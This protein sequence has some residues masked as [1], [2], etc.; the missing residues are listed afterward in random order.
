MNVLHL[1]EKH[2]LAPTIPTIING[3]C[4]KKASSYA[5]CVTVLTGFKHFFSC[6]TGSNAAF[7]RFLENPRL[8]VACPPPA[9]CFTDRCSL[10]HIAPSVKPI[11]LR[12]TAELDCPTVTGTS[13]TLFRAQ[14]SPGPRSRA[15]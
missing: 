10:H 8:M 11:L 15:R 9:F 7:Q 6:L 4:R 1:M 13:V 5:R 12:I 3:Y 2:R 14:S